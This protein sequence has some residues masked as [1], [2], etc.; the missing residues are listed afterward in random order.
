MR[1][2]I[3]TVF[4]YTSL[5]GLQ[6][7][8]LP[9]DENDIHIE[10]LERIIQSTFN[11]QELVERYPNPEMRIAILQNIYTLENKGLITKGV[12][13]LLKD[14]DARV[15]KTLIEVTNHDPHASLWILDLFTED[16]NPAIRA[17]AATATRYI[18]SNQREIERIL[19][20]LM[21]DPDP[22]VR[23]EVA[24]AISVVRDDQKRAERTLN[25]LVHD[26]DPTVR[27]AVIIATDLLINEEEVERM[28][29]ILEQDSDVN[30]QIQAQQAI[31]RRAV[32]SEDPISI[33]RTVNRFMESPSIEIR[34]AIPHA[35]VYVLNKVT[36]QDRIEILI[37][38][39]RDSS[40]EVRLAVAKATQYLQYNLE[41]AESILNIL[42]QDSDPTV[43][44]HAVETAEI[45][46]GDIDK[47][48]L[49][50]H[51]KDP[52]PTVRRQVAL[53]AGRIGG[54][55]NK[56]ILNTLAKDKDPS[57]R[58]QV[59][60]SAIDLG[61]NEGGKILNILAKD[62]DPSV[63]TQAADS[64]GHLGG[65]RGTRILNTLMKDKDPTVR[66]QVA[67]SASVLEDVREGNRI[68]NILKH[69][70]D[71]SVRILVAVSAV[72]LGTEPFIRRS[73]KLTDAE[74]EI[75]KLGK[76][77]GRR[78]LSDLSKDQDPTVRGNIPF[79]VF[80]SASNIP[81]ENKAI[82]LQSMAGD[83]HPLVR[84]EV[85]ENVSQLQDYN[86]AEEVLNLLTN[87]TDIEVIYTVV[88]TSLNLSQEIAIR[89]IS[90]I[91]NNHPDL[92]TKRTVHVF[93]RSK[94]PDILSKIEATAS[95]ACEEGFTS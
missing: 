62:K 76:V 2:I 22:T 54:N 71:P 53:S 83:K 79:V 52:S 18:K 70:P 13:I 95:R 65:N 26:Q 47:K 56:K 36:K 48:I 51:V 19:N 23:A 34:K 94:F 58:I 64:A 10:N 37:N 50:T 92:E 72:R 15:R 21:N 82:G 44:K 4:I 7:L 81:E 20:T 25:I 16:S 91:L 28:L 30:V 5:T 69:D 39:A 61:G 86:K 11:I 49:S 42:E 1:K 84:K 59:A 93:V 77:A 45:L 33:M 88:K 8:A 17:E 87:D 35:V 60:D 31:L 12:N 40:P 6:A 89:I 38:L 63:R 46:G 68:L 27:I 74:Q 66:G 55:E 73:H 14:P 57:V 41:G 80:D 3:I 32:Q 90:Q 29:N 75:I 78:I 43:R 24:T 9:S 85:A 67:L